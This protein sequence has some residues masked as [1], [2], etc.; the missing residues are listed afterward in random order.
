MYGSVSKEGIGYEE[1]VLTFFLVDYYRHTSSD[2]IQLK[3]E[4]ID[5][6]EINP[7]MFNK[8][9]LNIPYS[10]DVDF[11]IKKESVYHIFFVKSSRKLGKIT[12]RKYIIEALKTFCSLESRKNLFKEDFA[13]YYISDIIMPKDIDKFKSRNDLQIINEIKQTI[14]SSNNELEEIFS[15]NIIDNVKYKTKFIE[16]K[17]Q[18]INERRRYNKKR[19]DDIHN[20]VAQKKRHIDTYIQPTNLYNNYD[21]VLGSNE[22]GNSFIYDKRKIYLGKEYEKIVNIANN[23]NKKNKILTIKSNLINPKIIFFNKKNL[24]E[25]EALELLSKF[26]NNIIFSS[27]KLK[28]ISI[29]ILEN[30]YNIIFFKNKEIYDEIKYHFNYRKGKYDLTK[31]KTLNYLDDQTKLK[32]ALI[33]FHRYS[34]IK[35]TKSSFLI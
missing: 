17:E 27:I 8:D 1:K 34:G 18:T 25:L 28:N 20:K 12:P 22:E 35:I 3:M 33:S 15:V 5:S 30:T 19:Y 31:V 6:W 23:F 13:F 4:E 21:I 16:L 26:F 24:N 29:I 7:K 2:T 32:V 9:I 11:Y 10:I 14:D